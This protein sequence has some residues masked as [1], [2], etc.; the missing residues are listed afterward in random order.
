[1]YLQEN[2]KEKQLLCV[3]GEKKSLVSFVQEKSLNQLYFYQ[4][5]LPILAF[6]FAVH[7]TTL[8]LIYLK[9]IL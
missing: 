1:M 7:S 4:L 8:T 2:K 3:A 9:V 6:H 5:F